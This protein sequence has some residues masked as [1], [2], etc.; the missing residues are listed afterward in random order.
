MKTLLDN[1]MPIFKEYGAF[2]RLLAGHFACRQCSHYHVSFAG[3]TILK[4]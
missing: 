4:Q 1:K 3:P 2:K